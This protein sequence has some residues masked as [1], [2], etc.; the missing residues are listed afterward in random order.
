LGPELKDVLARSDFV[1]SRAGA[2]SIFEIL[3]LQKPM[4]LVPLEVGSRGD[5][6]INAQ[7]FQKNNWALVLRETE[8]RD[9]MLSLDKL[10]LFKPDPSSWTIEGIPKTLAEIHQTM[11]A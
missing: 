10:L 3:A 4:L 1:V 5:Q 7:I 11:K 6:V 9:F 8:Q 2:N